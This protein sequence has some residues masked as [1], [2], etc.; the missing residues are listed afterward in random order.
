MPFYPGQLDVIAVGKLRTREWQAA[1]REYGKRIK[2]YIKLK[3]T[4]VRDAPGSL[5]AAVALQR[6]GEQLLQAAQQA[7]RIILLTPDGAEMDSPEFAAFLRKQIE[8]YG[9]VAWLI[10]GPLGVAEEVAT[11]AHTTFALSRL[12]FPHEMARVILLEQLY[13]AFTIMRGESYHK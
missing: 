9:R 2:H 8:V 3:L 1:Q 10:G 13:R 11:A 12:T 5:P 6:E 7:Q 4:E